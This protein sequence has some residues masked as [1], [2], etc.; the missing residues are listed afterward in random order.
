MKFYVRSAFRRITLGDCES[1]QQA[2]DLFLSAF[3]QEFR[4]GDWITCSQ[5]GYRWP[6]ESDSTTYECQEAVK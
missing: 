4:G 2:V 5:V 1:E 6:G 3:R